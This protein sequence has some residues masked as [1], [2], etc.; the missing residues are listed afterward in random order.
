MEVWPDSDHDVEGHQDVGPSF[1]DV[2]EGALADLEEAWPDDAEHEQQQGDREVVASRL[3]KAADILMEGKVA[4]F[5]A[6]GK[7]LQC[8]PQW[9]SVR[10]H[11]LG[12][13]GSFS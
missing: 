13:V 12:R 9:A 8:Q 6:I 10:F 3:H 2:L 7:Q 4:P 1:G 11:E 5:E